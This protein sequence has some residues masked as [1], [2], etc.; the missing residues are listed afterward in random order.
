MQL[1]A[2]LAMLEHKEKPVEVQITMIRPG[3]F[4]HD[5][6]QLLACQPMVDDWGL[7]HVDFSGV[8]GLRRQGLTCAAVGTDLA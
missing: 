8:K 5:E 6:R 4:M 7:R 3:P 2:R 1:I